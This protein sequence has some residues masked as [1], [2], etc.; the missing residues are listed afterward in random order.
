VTLKFKVE[1]KGWQIVNNEQFN[2]QWKEYCPK[3]KDWNYCVE[4]KKQHK[5]R[6]LAETR[7]YHWVVV[8]VLANYFEIDIASMHS[9][10][11]YKFLSKRFVWV[12]W[13]EI[14][15]VWSTKTLTTI[16]FEAF[17]EEIRKWF[18]SEYWEQLPYP[19]ETME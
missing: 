10:L 13:W 8:P 7:F 6:T 17:I 9:E 18:A 15:Q 19:H 1:F 11:K 14:V 16:E 3:L 5:Q 12:E 2:K 4:I